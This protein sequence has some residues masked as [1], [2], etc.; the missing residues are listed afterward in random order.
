MTPV[1]TVL[2]LLRAGAA[3]TGGSKNN[4]VACMLQLFAPL[5]EFCIRLKVK[6]ANATDT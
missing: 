2:S 1:K 4:D 3:W 5:R 6:S